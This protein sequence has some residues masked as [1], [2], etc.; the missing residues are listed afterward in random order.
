[1]MKS[2]LMQ[3]IFLISYWIVTLAALNLGITAVLSYDPMA[4]IL[5]KLNMSMLMMP[6]H[7]IIGVAAVIT[8]LA[9]LGMKGHCHC[10]E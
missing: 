9:L 1:M 8:L 5:D 4:K 10:Q 6:L 2:P 3:Y 7:Y